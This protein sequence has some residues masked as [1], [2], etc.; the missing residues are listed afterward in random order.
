MVVEK[1][2]LMKASPDEILHRVFGFSEYRPGQEKVI[3]GLIAGQDQFVLMP[4]GGGKSL[5]YQV[6]ALVLEGVAVV[7]SPLIALM[8]DQVDALLANGV[9]AACYNSSLSPDEARQVLEKLAAKELDLLYVAPERI[10]TE[11]FLDRLRQAQI[12]L[13]AID[14][15]HCVS[16]WGHDFRPEYVQLGQ[17]RDI[18]PEVPLVALTATADKPTRQDIIKFLQLERAQIYVGSFNRPNIRYTIVDKHQ[19]F[20][21]LMHFLN[22][23]AGESGII[24]C[25]TRKQVEEVS[26]KLQS[27]SINALPYHAGLDKLLRTKTQQKFRR[28]DIQIIVATVAFGMGI[29]KPNVRYVVH[30]DVPK[31]IECYYQETGR[32]GRDG[33]PAEAL[34]LYGLGDI[35]KVRGMIEMSNNEAQKRIELHKL[36][37]MFGFAES[38]GCRRR[39]LL[40]Y[41]SEQLKEDCGNCDNCLNPPET[42]SGLIVAQKVL[43]CVLRVHQ[44]FGMKHIV[45]ILRG[46]ESQ[47]ITQ[48]GHERLSTYGIGKDYSVAEW[49]SIIRQLIH[50]GYLEQD[51]TQYSVLKITP[52]AREILRGER[53]LILAKPRIKIDKP[54][55]KPSAKK[56]KFE[57]D[58]EEDKA[59]FQKLRQLRREL[60]LDANVPPFVVFS[61]A[62]L[63]EMAATR[64]R[65]EAEFLDINGVGARKLA[66]YGQ[67]FLSV[68]NELS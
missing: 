49:M 59:L 40:N 15:A 27:E 53:E 21:Q 16:Q 67:A 5:C 68:I 32:A 55:K 62:S 48:F 10:L 29:D 58:R 9:K 45:D 18:F 12:S 20:S 3:K 25:A 8:Q 50:Y 63:A 7:V 34:M 65:N 57:L 44:R 2:A 64:P 39:V 14:E 47:R 26:A 60:A 4:T 19:P 36:N 46:V 17:L 37:A 38:L 31:N 11:S 66:V 42:F 52:Q 41:F 28:D 35:A 30:Y 54:S 61:D 43:S 6:P 22:Q 24:Y 56:M 23:Q 1:A 51:I 33:L 13:F